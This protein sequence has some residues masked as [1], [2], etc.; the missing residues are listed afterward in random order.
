MR[1]IKISKGRIAEP[2]LHRHVSMTWKGRELLGEVIGL[3]YSHSRGYINLDVRH[4]NGELWPLSPAV[5]AVKLI[6]V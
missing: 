3:V 6:D 4:F 2:I 1:P 5:S